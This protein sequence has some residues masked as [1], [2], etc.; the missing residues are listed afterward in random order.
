MILCE[1]VNVSSFDLRLFHAQCTLGK[2]DFNI[3][4]VGKLIELI[5]LQDEC[6]YSWVCIPLP[7]DHESNLGATESNTPNKRG[8][9]TSSSASSDLIPSGHH[10]HLHLCTC[11]DKG[12]VN[13][14]SWNRNR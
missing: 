14:N 4:I 11:L 10:H 12:R 3:V 1:L 2:R 6:E 8:A 13:N 7:N 9:R 5:V